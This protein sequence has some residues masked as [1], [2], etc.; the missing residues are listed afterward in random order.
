MSA[1]GANFAAFKQQPL[2]GADA[3]SGIAPAFDGGSGVVAAH[4]PEI[5]RDSQDKGGKGKDDGKGGKDPLV[6]QIANLTG[7]GIVRTAQQL[8]KTSALPP[9]GEVVKLATGNAAWTYSPKT[10]LESNRYNHW[11]SAS[12]NG[13]TY[14]TTNGK[15]IKVDG[16]PFNSATVAVPNPSMPNDWNRQLTHGM[17]NARVVGTRQ[18]MGARASQYN[19]TGVALRA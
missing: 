5:Y 4:L 16:M 7:T 12:L 14:L 18:L 1:S 15:P 8:K 19:L 9:K 6:A 13:G 3:G 11:D 17:T 2:R 10:K